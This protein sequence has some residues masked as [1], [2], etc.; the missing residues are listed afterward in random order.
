M[1]KFLLATVATVSLGFS[2][3]TAE[4]IKFCS[5]VMKLGE[6]CASQGIRGYDC[7]T[8]ADIVIA[9]GVKKGI[10][11]DLVFSV[12]ELCYLAC[13]SPLD[14]NSNKYELFHRCLYGGK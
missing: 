13:K 4:H 3:P 10:P 6:Y 5:I 7:G 2:A 9:E 14:F 12:S 11:E 8:L 1:K